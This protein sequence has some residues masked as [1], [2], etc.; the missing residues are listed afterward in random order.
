MS[1][2][3]SRPA[4]HTGY[5]VIVVG[6]GPAGATAAYYLALA[7]G[8][9]AGLRVAL[10]EKER[11]PRDKIC[12]D[13]WCAPALD[14]L[15]EMGVLQQLEA[16]GL[17]RDC[18]SGGFVSPSG[19]SYI[20]TGDGGGAPGTRC[21]AI[22]R[23]ICDERIARRAAQVGAEL[24]EEAEFERAELADDGLWSVQ[25]R[26][27][28]CL[29]ARM[30]VAAD[31]ATSRVARSLGIVETPPLGVAARQYV[32]GGT[33][34]FK[35]G[36]VLLYPEYILPG[37][38]ALFRHY[39]DVI[40]LGAYVIPGGALAPE[41]L[42]EVYRSRIMHD[43]FIQRVLGPGAEFLERV[44]VA[45]L[46]TGGEPRSSALQFMAVGDA[47]G[48]TDP[49]T[50][51]G[52]HTGMIGARLAAETI[53]ELFARDDFSAEACAVYH[54]RWM[55]AFG[56]DF[57]ASAA[58][59]RMTYRF[60]FFLD[61]ANVVAQR[62][63]DSFMA[64]FGAAMT[65]VKPKT[66]FV[67][68]AVALPLGAE[69]VR[70]I[71]VQRVRRPFES[72]WQAYETRGR[73]R[74]SR[75]TAFENS[76]L[77]DSAVSR[78]PAQSGAAGRSEPG[79]LARI[80]RY[81][82]R[83]PVA[84]RVLVVYGSEYGFAQQLAERVCAALAELRVGGDGARLSPVCVDSE[85]HEIVDWSEVD[86]CLLIC[87]TA[88]DG[89]APRAARG[90]F[91][92]LEAGGLDL[93]GVRY[94][95]LALGD[96]SYPS[97]CRA[98]C[99]LDSLMASR[100]AQPLTPVVQVDREAP[101]VIDAWL[102]TLSARM[103]DAGFWRGRGPGMDEERLRERAARHLGALAGDVAEG[104]S[105][106]RPLG[107][108]LVSRRALCRPARPGDRDTVHLELEL[109]EDGAPPWQPGDA[110]G[111]LA[112]N[113][114]AEVEAV[115]GGLGRSGD[116]RVEIAEGRADVSL[117]EALL[118]RIDIKRLRA[119][120]MQAL[121]AVAEPGGERER[122]AGLCDDADAAGRYLAERELQDVLRDFPVA[123]RRLP[124]GEL[125]QRVGRIAPRYYSIASAAQTAPGRLSLAVAIVRYEALGRARTGLASTFLGERVKPGDTIPIFVQ[126]NPDFRLPPA[127]GGASCVMIGAGTGLAP[128][129]A[130]LQVLAQRDRAA[131]HLLFCGCRHRERDCS[132]VRCP[133]AQR[134][135]IARF[136]KTL[137][138]C[139]DNDS[140][141]VEFFSKPVGFNIGN[142]RR[143]MHCVS[144]D[145]SL[146][147][148]K[149]HCVVPAGLQ[150]H[151]H[152]R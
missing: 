100:G 6:A 51:E 150:R 123:A 130:F 142:S 69:V 30:L 10:I 14:I 149:T 36:G 32:R 81:A 124:A 101:A 21:Y 68:P 73:A 118:H 33:H 5:D 85:H 92:C 152:Q 132:R 141:F 137:E 147:S 111:V 75:A 17:V 119:E 47:A 144:F 91:E 114:P 58:G 24:R 139:H 27:G 96:R 97:F 151:C 143:S 66:T 110:L 4:S 90:L 128:Y 25:C 16:E 125:L 135:N 113:C 95:V 94:S 108:R 105:R 71:F 46:R 133:A 50:G 145:P 109:G 117:R 57:S 78:G 38:V 43:P 67:K 56:R 148:A 48:Q 120:L 49:L 86:A 129:R 93:S 146:R 82:A 131:P 77:R 70:Q 8:G 107:A 34:N 87:S 53:Q 79:A 7:T 1:S 39:D 84:G 121:A 122:L 134:R 136:G 104:S 80:F 19:E 28:R 13:A 140:A 64:E 2:F 26:D 103:A 138:P 11:L 112:S 62:K 31:G 42:L 35:S 98:G 60:P 106:E 40:D 15:E 76:C 99:T 29:R 65:G 88:G 23:M 3:D 54:R 52:I 59:G 37:Y 126:P 83:G 72:G 61:A 44:R 89:V 102:A 45:S 20:A 127:D 74:G 9:R 12:G 22:K 115:L 55:K 41:E 116:E 18:T 63:G